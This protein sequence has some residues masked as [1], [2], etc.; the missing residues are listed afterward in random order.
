MRVLTGSRTATSARRSSRSTMADRYSAGRGAIGSRRRPGGRR[1]RLSCG[2]QDQRR[3]RYCQDD[4]GP[5]LTWASTRSTS[6][7]CATGSS[8][9]ERRRTDPSADWSGSGGRASGLGDWLSA[10][11]FAEPRHPSRKSLAASPHHPS[12]WPGRRQWRVLGRQGLA[13]EG[14]PGPDSGSAS[15]LLLDNVNLPLSGL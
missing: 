14:V 10:V 6:H 15:V 2:A 1:R 9:T 12:R 5:H 7:V 3:D 13:A 8:V 4:Q 11:V